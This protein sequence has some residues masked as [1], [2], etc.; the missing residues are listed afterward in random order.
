M[1]NGLKGVDYAHNLFP[2]SEDEH[3]MFTVMQKPDLLGQ[4]LFLSIASCRE[5]RTYNLQVFSDTLM[6]KQM[7]CIDLLL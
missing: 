6:A 5:P 2:Y 1:G 3:R 7:P 4:T